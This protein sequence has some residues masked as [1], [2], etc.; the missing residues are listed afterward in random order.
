MVLRCPVCRGLQ[1]GR[2]GSDQYFC[3]NCCL[4]FN[5]SRGRLNLYE[6]AEDGTL[7]AMERSSE[8]L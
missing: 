3:S 1:I 2:V 4:E 7:I 5:Y 6:V 8:L